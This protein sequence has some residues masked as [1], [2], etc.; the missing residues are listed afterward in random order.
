M[1]CEKVEKELNRLEQLGIIS[2]VQH[3]QWAAPIV[4]ISKR[5]GTLRICGDF[6]TTSYLP[7]TKS[8]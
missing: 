1:L 7:F 6:K 8:R 2:P 3:S 5:E 4:P